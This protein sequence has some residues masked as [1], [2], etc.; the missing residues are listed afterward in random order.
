MFPLGGRKISR[1][2]N[3]IP[4]SPKDETK[5]R[6]S[7]RPG[8]NRSSSVVP[9][10]AVRER[11]DNVRPRVRGGNHLKG[12]AR[13]GE[14]RGNL[15]LYGAADDDGSGCLGAEVDGRQPALGCRKECHKRARPVAAFGEELHLHVDEDVVKVRYGQFGARGAREPWEQVG[16]F[17]RRGLSR[18]GDRVDQQYRD[19]QSQNSQNHFAHTELARGRWPWLFTVVNLLET[20]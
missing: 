6:A 9:P 7:V 10:R 12:F 16:E 1:V 13:P 14:R 17:T 8:L 3:P 15:Y 20:R 4:S 18:A 11:Y 2:P 5:S 19:Q